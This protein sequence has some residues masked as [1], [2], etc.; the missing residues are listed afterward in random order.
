MKVYS[1]ANLLPFSHSFSKD[2]NKHRRK[3]YAAFPN[4]VSGCI[5]CTY[6]FCH[7]AFTTL[8]HINFVTLDW[9]HDLGHINFVTSYWSHNSWSY[10]FSLITL[11]TLLSHI[12]LS[13]NLGHNF[14]INVTVFK[15][16]LLTKGI[17]SHHIL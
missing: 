4:P 12:T 13:C 5:Y 6:K 16:L 2:Q 1:V 7:K 17:S 8:G 15:H 3:M 9:S 11:V 14:Y 10:N